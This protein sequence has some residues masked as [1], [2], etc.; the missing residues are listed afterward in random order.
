A[1]SCRRSTHAL[2]GGAAGAGAGVRQRSQ[3]E[4]E[5][6]GGERAA[7]SWRGR[8]PAATAPA[9]AAGC[10]GAAHG[11]FL[12]RARGKVPHSTA[13]G[14]APWKLAAPGAA[15]VQRI[16]TQ[17]GILEV[18]RAGRGEVPTQRRA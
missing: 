2:A 9:P 8:V 11:A 16:A 1:L 3:G 7:L 14:S 18:G 13:R 10:G 15:K 17:P 6:E 5:G 4:G 12:A